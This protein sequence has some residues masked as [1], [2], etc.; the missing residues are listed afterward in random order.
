[1]GEPL[2]SFLLARF[3][4]L[5]QHRGLVTGTPGRRSEAMLFTLGTQPGSR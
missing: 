3:I 2:V 5:L 4:R 1:M